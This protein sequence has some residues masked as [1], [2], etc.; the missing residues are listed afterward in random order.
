MVVESS[1]RPIFVYLDLWFYIA[2]GP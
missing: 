1:P 2:V